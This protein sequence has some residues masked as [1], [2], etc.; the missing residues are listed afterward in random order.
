MKITKW[1]KKVA[2]RCPLKDETA[3]EQTLSHYISYRHHHIYDS[4]KLAN[5]LFLFF[6]N[7]VPPPRSHRNVDSV[8][9][10]D[11]NG[12]VTIPPHVHHQVEKVL[13]N[14][15]TKL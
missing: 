14:P 6:G 12:L 10:E 7:R 8:P 3:F 2:D 13:E 4:G 15:Y 9:L 11:G 1:A 5:N